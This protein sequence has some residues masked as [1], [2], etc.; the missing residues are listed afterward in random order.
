MGY[1]A[2]EVIYRVKSIMDKWTELKLTTGG[3]KTTGA[4]IKSL[5]R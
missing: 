2:N 1:K 4:V 3:K 5:S